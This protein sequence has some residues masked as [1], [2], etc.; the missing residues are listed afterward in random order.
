MTKCFY[1][2]H[3]GKDY[4][5]LMYDSLTNR[6]NC[7]IC[8]TIIGE[9]YNELLPA[10]FDVP[11]KDLIRRSFEAHKAARSH[12]EAILAKMATTLAND[13][14]SACTGILEPSEGILKVEVG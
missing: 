9:V 4:N 7:A 13:P 10:E 6:Y 14:K 3:D 12:R 5:Y 8:T 11:Y 1:C 2:D